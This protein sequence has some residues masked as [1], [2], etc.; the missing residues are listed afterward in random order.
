LID[1]KCLSANG[2]RCF[3]IVLRPVGE[4]NCFLSDLQ[5]RSYLKLA[6]LLP[7]PGNSRIYRI[8]I[9]GNE[10]FVPPGLL[11]GLMYAWYLNNAYGSTIDYEMALLRWSPAALFPHQSKERIRKQGLVTF[12]RTEIFGYEPLFRGG[13]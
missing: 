1:N 11:F 13:S 2:A 5:L 3:E 10:G 12:F 4:R 6:R 8:A 9:N 7:D